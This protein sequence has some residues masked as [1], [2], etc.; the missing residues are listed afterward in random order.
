M[1]YLSTGARFAPLNPLVSG[2]ML[3][4]RK[5]SSPCSRSLAGAP[6]NFLL[7]RMARDSIASLRFFED[8]ARAGR[9]PTPKKM[10]LG[11][12]GKSSRKIPARLSPSFQCLVMSI[13]ESKPESELFLNIE[14]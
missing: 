14:L 6:P 5:N 3:P 9:L 10:D 12:V 7:A 1:E 11:M 4:P 8:E 2:A 13:V